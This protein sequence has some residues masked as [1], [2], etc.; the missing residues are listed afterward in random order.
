FTAQGV[1]PG[2]VVDFRSGS[3]QRCSV[4]IA[5]IDSNPATSAP[6]RRN[7]PKLSTLIHSVFHGLANQAAGYLATWIGTPW[8]IACHDGPVRRSAASSVLLNEP[9]Q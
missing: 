6:S 9:P 2:N 1:D 8:R 5:G 7:A 4:T 3:T